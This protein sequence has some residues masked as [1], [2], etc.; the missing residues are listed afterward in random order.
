MRDYTITITL[1]AND[2]Q[3]ALRAVHAVGVELIRSEPWGPSAGWASTDEFEVAYDVTHNGPDPVGI[4]Q[5]GRDGEM[6]ASTRSSDDDK[7]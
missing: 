4:I 7:D 3:G 6:S 2:L 1:G 5:I